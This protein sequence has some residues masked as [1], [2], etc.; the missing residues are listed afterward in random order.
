MSF[1]LIDLSSHFC[2]HLFITPIVLFYYHHNFIL[3][4]ALIIICFI[5]SFL[6][7][8]L[9]ILHILVQRGQSYHSIHPII[10]HWLRYFSLRGCLMGW[11]SCTHQWFERVC[12]FL[13]SFPLEFDL[14]MIM[15]IFFYK[16]SA[17]M[18]LC[19]IFCSIGHLCCLLR[20]IYWVYLSLWVLVRFSCIFTPWV[21]LVM[22]LEC[23]GFMWEFYEIRCFLDHGW[24]VLGM[25]Y[26]WP[27]Y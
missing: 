12:S 10:W 8:G 27:F 1:R 7:L 15:C 2:Y 11:G 25:R 21:T 24:Y 13:V 5:L 26:E 20:S 14:L 17:M 19:M 4:L 16:K 22:H 6:F 3:F 23:W 9:M 18:C